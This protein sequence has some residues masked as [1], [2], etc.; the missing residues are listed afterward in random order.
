MAQPQK[1]NSALN[2]QNR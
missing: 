2:S 1:L